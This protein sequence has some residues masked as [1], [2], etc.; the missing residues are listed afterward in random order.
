[1]TKI[2]ILFLGALISDIG[3]AAEFLVGPG[4][5]YEKPS[6]VAA[7]VRDGD[8]VRIAAGDYRGDVAVWRKND[9]F[10]QGVGGTPHLIADGNAAEGKAIWVIKG[11][12]TI[13]EN[14]EFSGAAVDD[15]NGAG[16]RLEGTNLTIRRCYFHDNENGVLTGVDP[17]SEILI[18]Y[19]EFANN[20]HGDGYSHNMYIGRVAKFT[21]QFSYVHHA[22]VGHQV[23]SRA[24]ENYIM[25]NRLMD[26]RSGTSSYIIDLPNPGKAVVVG[27][28]LQQGASAENWAMIHSAQPLLLVNNTVVNDRSSGIFVT[29]S[30]D[31]DASLLQNNIFV[32][33]GQ[34]KASGARILSNLLLDDA[35]LVNRHNYDYRLT[36]DSAAID[37]GT[38]PGGT[39]DVGWEYVHKAQ[40]VERQDPGPV[41]IGAHAWRPEG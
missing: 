26:E 13:V 27:N 35:G 7:V 33:K 2:Q 41:D 3:D 31:S 32:G 12:D 14:I 25:F 24:A 18:E 30:G 8:T 37:A 21:L 4:M 9:L 5:P 38:E 6:E 36:S 29:L 1:M 19:S 11:N 20:G 40:A 34:V 17:E 22:R 10:I 16:I 28:E 15:A 39:I 23:K